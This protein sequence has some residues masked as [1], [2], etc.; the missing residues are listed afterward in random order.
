MKSIDIF[1]PDI[2]TVPIED[3]LKR[4]YLDYAMSVIVSR[5]LPDVRDGL[6]P[7]HRRIL[8][9]M[10]EDGFDYNKPY[11]KSARIVGQVIAK[12]HPH[13]NDAIYDAMVRMAQH[14]SMS[15]MLIDGHGNFG[16]MDGDKAAAMRYT[17]ARLSRAAHFLL[18]DYD[19][20]TVDFQPNYDETLTMPTVLPAAFP[21]IIVNGASG[22]AVG[23]ATNIPTHNLGEVIDGCCALIDNPDLSVD[24]VMQYIKGPDFCTGGTI[25]GR[26]GIINAYT[27]GRGTFVIRSKTD[28]EEFKKDRYAI[29]V[30]EIPY[31]VNKASMVE[32]IADLV[33]NK[34]LDGISDIR[35]ESDR[36]GVRVVIELRRDATPEVVLNKLYASTPLQISFNANIL[37]LHNGRP[38]QMGI[39]EILRAFIEFRVE[40]VTRRTKFFLNK[41]RSQASVIAGLAVAI[42]S[43]DEVIAMI[44]GA[45]DPAD[46]LKKLMERKWPIDD[47]I[48]AYLRL[49]DSSAGRSVFC[50]D[51]DL[52]DTGYH[53]SEEQAKAILALRL[54]RLTGMEREK[55]FSDLK[56]LCDDISGYIALLASPEKV[57]SLIKEELVYVKTTLSSPRKSK[58]VDDDGAVGG[59][60]LSL[61][62]LEE[63]V[64]TVSVRGYIKRVPLSVYRSQKRGGRGR[65]AMSTRDEDVV[66]QVFITDTHTTLLFFSSFGKA[67]QMMVHELPCCS[68]TS[69]GKPIVSLIPVEKGETISTLLQLPKDIAVSECIER[70]EISC[71]PCGERDE[72]DDD[73]DLESEGSSEESSGRIGNQGADIIFSTS[74]GYVRK[75]SL[76]DFLSIRSNGKIAMKLSDGERL[77][78]V[79]LADDDSDV[80]LSTKLG[81]SIRFSSKL[82]RRFS[83]RTSIGVRGIK[84]QDGDEV[85][86]MS[87]LKT[88]GF[89]HE[90]RE[91]YMKRVVKESSC[92]DREDALPGEGSD[93]ENGIETVSDQAASGDGGASDYDL[94]PDVELAMTESEQ[95]IL[96]VSSKG[97]GK[98]TLSYAYRSSGR[99]GQGVSSMSINK[100]TGE[101]VDVLPVL[102]DDDIILLTDKGQLLR[103]P[104]KDIRITAR[105]TQGVKLFKLDDGESIVSVAASSNCLDDGVVAESFSSDGEGE[106]KQTEF[107]LSKE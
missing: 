83:G 102:A 1:Q 96:S 66:E 99:G 19:R 18:E 48:S 67:Y 10:I 25:Y 37:A 81:K 104:V 42:S 45:T 86:A 43:I 17:E 98:R 51:S 9:A 40:V 87:I 72:S 29:I 68:P 64:V 54:Q 3:E 90:E 34:E 62:Q 4:S 61:I 24:G 69:L 60:D 36:N 88:V 35:D 13:G 73:L 78:S 28:I 65:S 100:K 30:T 32:R 16:S 47:V 39:L 11:K 58:I 57:F 71:A 6:K 80:L 52:H 92:C 77:I 74:S 31:Q 70:E 53:L 75:N 15:V 12:Y 93:G 59:N 41:A 21:N 101:L 46:A 8:Y 91:K 95:M 76:R 26:K 7:V 49:L 33:N 94:N 84:L 85:V 97:F 107:D 5:A 105:Y 82:L 2:I 50:D 20:D 79:A 27:T 56:K 63:M 38:S 89:S 14:F 55:L 44:K 22:I 23:M 103:C 106:H